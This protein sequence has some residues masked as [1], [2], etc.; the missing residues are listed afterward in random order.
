[1]IT[2]ITLFLLTII[3]TNLSAQTWSG[4][5][6][7][8]IFY[9]SGNVGIGTSTPTDALSILG[10]TQNVLSAKFLSHSIVDI[11]SGAGY[12]SYLKFR[13]NGIDK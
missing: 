5:T 7:G 9:N 11:E 6:P 13:N 2:K 3:T 10:T 1:M 12:N 4:T 8:N